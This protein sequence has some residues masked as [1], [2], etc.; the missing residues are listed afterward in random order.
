METKQV[1]LT[2]DELAEL[3]A[4]R[5]E[6]AKKGAEQKAKET[7]E[8]YKT[9]VDEQINEI[10][11]VLFEVSKNLTLQK[12]HCL[13]MFKQ[14]IAMKS[15]IFKV[16]DN[17]MSHTFTNSDGDKRITIGIYTIDNYR[18]T[19]NEGIAIVK[20]VISS[21]ATDKESKVLVDA[22]LKLLSKDQKGNLKASRVLQ[23]RKMADEIN[24]DRF[25]EGVKII[26]EAYQPL[27]SKTY[28]RAEYKDNNGVFVNVPLG[29][30]EA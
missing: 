20:E 21:L 18:D 22:V 7:R 8:A 2:H 26:Q 25:K 28:V 23:L 14:A 17:Q 29:M 11:P 24:N 16:K 27:I 3:E 15:E 1:E 6:K 4:F 10:F 5:A 12:N 19:V 9:L 30:T 13:Q